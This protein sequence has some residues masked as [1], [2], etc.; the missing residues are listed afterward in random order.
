MA[1]LFSKIIDGELPARFVWRDPQVVAFLTIAPLRPGHT[2]VV[3]RREVDHWPDVDDTL[4][5]HCTRVAQIIG[6]GVQRGWDAPRAGLVIAGFEVQHLHLH[7]FPAWGLSDFDFAHVDHD[8]DPDDLDRA[9][10]TLRATLRELGYADTV[11]D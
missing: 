5:R 7:V 4:M 9:A 3:P 2:L 6:R 11:P 10:E 1:T 8:P